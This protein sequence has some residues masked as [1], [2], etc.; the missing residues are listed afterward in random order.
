MPHLTTLSEDSMSS[1]IGVVLLNPPDSEMDRGRSISRSTTP[2]S[3]S[4]EIIQPTP[5]IEVVEAVPV[6]DDKDIGM[7]CSLKKLYSGKEDKH[8]RFQWQD[9]VPK[10]VGTPVENDAIA[11]FALIVRYGKVYN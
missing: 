5:N 7:T 10:D 9:T 2:S 1:S 4:M 8:G 6:V 3:S 11:K